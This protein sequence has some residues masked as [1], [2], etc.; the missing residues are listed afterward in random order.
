MNETQLTIS[1]SFFESRLF[2]LFT[3]LPSNHDLVSSHTPFFPFRPGIL[4]DI[5]MMTVQGRLEIEAKRNITT[6]SS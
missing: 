5:L 3:L 1:R 4:C 6:R 2:P